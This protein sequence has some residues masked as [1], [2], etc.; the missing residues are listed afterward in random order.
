VPHEPKSPITN[1]ETIFPVRNPAKAFLSPVPEKR[2]LEL[3]PALFILKANA[4]NRGRIETQFFGRSGA[5][6]LEII[7]RRPLISMIQRKLLSIVAEIPNKVDL[8][9]QSIQES[10]IALD[11][12]FENCYHKAKYNWSMGGCQVKKEDSFRRG[13]HVVFALHAHIVFIPRYRK[14]IFD[15]DMLDRVKRIFRVVCAD[16]ETD[17]VE[18]NGEED[19]IHLLINYP[20]KM[21]LSALVNSLK[22][23]SARRLRQERPT[24][25]SQYW[26]GG[27]WSASYFVSS[28]GG[29]PV[30]ILRQYIQ[31]QKSIN[32]EEEGRPKVGPSLLTSPT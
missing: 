2:L 31:N 27:F 10:E 26:K 7:P 4:L 12:I 24:I 17:I 29:A 20:P 11:S 30:N 13:R 14:K 25:N 8:A 28:C 5:K 6:I 23:V 15:A 22:G 21:A 32:H 1:R 16:F 18:F 19:H 9:R 3:A